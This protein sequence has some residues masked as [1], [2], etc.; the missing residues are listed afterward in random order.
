MQQSNEQNNETLKKMVRMEYD[1]EAYN[2]KMLYEAMVASQYIREPYVSLKVNEWKQLRMSYRGVNCDYAYWLIG[3]P[4]CSVSADGR[5]S[6]V[7]EHLEQPITL[8]Q[9]SYHE[10]DVDEADG[11]VRPRTDKC[12]YGCFRRGF[13]AETEGIFS[14]NS[15][16]SARQRVVS[17]R[18]TRS[19]GNCQKSKE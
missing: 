5:E 11:S 18:S 8:H 7:P 6:F 12:H 1:G 17:Q 15:H 14:P 9:P 2:I 19:A 10:E 16:S 13:N 3:E 4:K